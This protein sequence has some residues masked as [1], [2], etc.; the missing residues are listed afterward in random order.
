MFKV[1]VGNGQT[2]AAEGVIQ[3]LPVWVQG[4]ELKI[5]VYLLPVAGVDLILGSSWLATL[6]PHVAGADLL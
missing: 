3:Q 6:G 2:I 4:H 5:L 1:L